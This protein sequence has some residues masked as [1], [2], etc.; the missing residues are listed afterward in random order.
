MRKRAWGPA[1][2]NVEEQF[3]LKRQVVLETAAKTFGRLGYERTT[4]AIIAGELNVAKPTLY[5][6]FKS[7][8]EILFEIQNTAITALLETV[9]QTSADDRSCIDRL[10]HFTSAYFHMITSDFGACLSTVPFHAL[11]KETHAQLL[12]TSRKV[13]QILREILRDG[14]AAGEF[15]PCDPKLTAALLFG[16]LNHLPTWRRAPDAPPIAELEGDVVQ[17]VCRSVVALR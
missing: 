13:D 10:R 8:D 15:A 12:I 3:Q 1:I 9:R 4:L 6:Y 17:F 11:K 2:Q 14:A 5:Y 16:S 7:K